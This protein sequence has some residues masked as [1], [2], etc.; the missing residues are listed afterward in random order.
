MNARR[1]VLALLLLGAAASAVDA[2]VVFFPNRGGFGSPRYGFG[3]YPGAFGG[4]PGFVAHPYPQGG[5]L[6]HRHAEIAGHDDHGSLIERLLQ[7][8]DLLG[9]LSSI[10]IA[11]TLQYA[12]QTV[13]CAGAA[14]GGC[15][16]PQNTR[17]GIASAG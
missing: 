3:G 10:H 12:Q 17:P 6:G 1:S 8:G 14:H 16:K 2:Q 5:G 15:R 13:R 9:F 11:F 4:Y 7:R